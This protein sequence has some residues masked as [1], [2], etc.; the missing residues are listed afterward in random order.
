MMFT[1]SCLSVAQGQSTVL[2]TSNMVANSTPQLCLTPAC[3]CVAAQE[4]ATQL[5]PQLPNL[6]VLALANN[7]I[8][9]PGVKALAAALHSL[10][11]LQVRACLR[12]TKAPAVLL[13]CACIACH[14]QC[15]HA[16]NGTSRS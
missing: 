10:Q 11:Q 16:H 13:P 3:L 2:E 8:K 7:S 14:W 5:L 6:T 9:V 12:F 4:L 1:A 15:S